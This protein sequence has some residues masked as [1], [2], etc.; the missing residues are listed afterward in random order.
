MRRLR[1]LGGLSIED[2]R[3]D[4]AS[5]ARRR[6]LALLALLAISGARGL[7]R[8]K[9]ASLLWPDSNEERAR[10]SLSQ[11]LTALRRDVPEGELVV[12]AAE[13]RLN[14]ALITSDVAEFEHFLSAGEP[15]RA[16][17]LYQG[18]FLDGFFVKDAA[19]FERWTDEHRRRLHEL[20]S[21]AVERLARQ[22]VERHD[23]VA[24][25]R[26]WRRLAALEPASARATAG[27][28]RALAATGDRAAA[29]QHYRVHEAL[30]RQEFGV[31]PEPDVAALAQR[32]RAEPVVLSVTA[33][34]APVVGKADAP[35]HVVAV[36]PRTDREATSTRAQ[37]PAPTRPAGMFGFASGARWALVAGAVGVVATALIAFRPSRPPELDP[38][39][40]VV[41]GFANRTGD[42]T[43][44]AL[45]FLAADVIIEA[46]QRSELVEVADPATSLITVT[47]IRNSGTAEG[48]EGEIAAQA[49]RAG[50]VV[51]GYY[52]REAESVVIAAR[53]ADAASGRI[54]G[55]TEP[56][57]AL[58]GAPREALE[59]IRQRV[60]GILAVR[61]DERLR[62][63]LTP[64]Y[65]PPPTLP[66]YREHVEGLLSFQRQKLSEARTHFQRARALDSTFIAPLI[67][68][69]FSLGDSFRSAEHNI[70]RRRVIEEIAR[71]RATL[72]PL[73]R[74]V[75]AYLEADE[76][77]DNDG[78]IAAMQRASDL[79]PHSLWTFWLA[80]SFFAKGLNTEAVAVFDRIDRKYG[81]TA[82]W[83]QFWVLYVE[84]LN[85]V[86]HRREL[87][88]AREARRALPNELQPLYLEARALVALRRWAE[89]DRVLTEMRTFPDEE[90]LLGN[91]LHV[92]GMAQWAQGDTLRAKVLVN[93]AVAWFRA[94]PPAELELLSRRRE[95]AAAL[96]NADQYAEA[97]AVY[98]RV[99]AEEP[100][101]HRA[102]RGIGICSARLGDRGRAEYAISQLLAEADSV[103]WCYIWAAGIAAVLGQQQRAVGFLQEFKNR[104]HPR[105]MRRFMHKDFD[106][107]VGYPPFMAITEPLR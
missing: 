71:R 73:D 85:R 52:A 72:T 66:A 68:E 48:A 13:L 89:L 95:F 104:G 103:D 30:L 80:R 101:E 17:E 86:D 38:R 69:V 96:L 5:P 29:L 20:Y 22:S 8:E 25:V 41:T 93:E 98:A 37:T 62:D 57:R 102:L 40:V 55:A 78:R 92:L 35:A 24:A 74:H 6:P 77:S 99:L 53:I 64:G 21:A 87:E 12:G 59:Q 94:L 46:L 15:E 105:I 70:A 84:A 56:V 18:P 3:L 88:V 7:S 58:P 39:R 4:A 82:M 90:R 10:N 31:E 45:G 36:D 2:G 79:A 63:V 100:K 61:L 43:L 44:D 83:P 19:T 49:T 91:L 32:L 42:S 27:L 11:A 1:T 51:S 81:W 76:R 14:P 107:M 60:L 23:T 34:E 106:G 97:C 33:S 9:I 16:V 54:L 50:L 75:L 47:G 67:W 65:T 28:M 26:W